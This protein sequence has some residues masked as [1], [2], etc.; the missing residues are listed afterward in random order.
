MDRAQRRRPSRRQP[1][2]PAESH[3]EQPVAAAPPGADRRR[4]QRAVGGLAIRSRLQR[5]AAPA[6]FAPAPTRSAATRA[7]RGATVSRAP[8][9]IQRYVE[10][11]HLQFGQ[12]DN[13]IGPEKKAHTVSPPPKTYTVAAGDTPDAIATRF[14]VPLDFLIARNASQCKIQKPARGDAVG[15][16]PPGAGVILPGKTLAELAKE[17]GVSEQ[18]LRDHNATAV[19]TWT[20]PDG[21]ATFEGAD[22]GAT[23]VVVTGKLAV[24]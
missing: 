19:K 1:I 8:I 24:T 2:E 3:P 22:R 23:L 15:G 17:A 5:P 6:D 13:L 4:L 9:A 12:V 7:V 10:G 11:E 16:F 20:V 14:G 18:T 21:G